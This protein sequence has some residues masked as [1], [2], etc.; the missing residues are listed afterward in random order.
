VRFGQIDIGAYEYDEVNFE[1][2][3]FSFFPIVV[4]DSGDEFDGEFMPEQLTLREAI[5][6]ANSLEGEQ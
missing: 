1:E 3:D 4:S 5:I 6:L 2:R